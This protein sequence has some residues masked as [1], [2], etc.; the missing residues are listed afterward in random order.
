VV[1]MCRSIHRLREGRTIDDRT[2]MEQAA[3]QYVRKVSGFT[4][5]AAHNEEAFA[6]AVADITDA[7]ERLM[8]SLVIR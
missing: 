1:I 4:T 8:E 3:L 7:T 5:P 2:A 6:R